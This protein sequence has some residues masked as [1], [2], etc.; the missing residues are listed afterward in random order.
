MFFRLLKLAWQNFFR[1]FGPSV[2]ATIIIILMLFF[3]SLFGSF[4]IL[5]GKVLEAFKEKIDLSLYLFPSVGEKETEALKKEIVEIAQVKEIIY[6]S[7]DQ[8]LEN[9]KISHSDDPIILKALKELDKNPLGPALIIKAVN[10]IDYQNILSL[11][12]QPRFKT[13][14]Y[15]QDFYDYQKII[16]RVDE[17]TKKIKTGVILISLVFIFASILVVFNTIRLTIY[18]RIE[19]IKIMRLVGA[20]SWF[21]RLPFLIEASFYGIFAWIFNSVILFLLASFAWPY[22]DKWLGLGFDFYS[23]LSKNFFV[24]LGPLFIFVFLLCILS[25]WLS[26]QKYLKV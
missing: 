3:L 15:N 25:S 22:F 19:E 2:V 11:I 8:S 13:I 12:S 7:S 18:S 4:N 23:Y 14:I 6:I 24:F 21:I 5:A 26:T 16:L 1:N 17:I 10:L 20:S 9:F